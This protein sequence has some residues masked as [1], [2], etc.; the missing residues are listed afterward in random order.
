M[1][2]L[3]HNQTLPKA[4]RKL[5]SRAESFPS[6]L[7]FQ[8]QNKSQNPDPKTQAN[9]KAGFYLQPGQISLSTAV[10]SVH[11]FDHWGRTPAENKN[12]RDWQEFYRF[13]SSKGEETIEKAIT[14][15]PYFYVEAGA[16][17]P[18]RK[19]NFQKNYLE[20]NNEKRFN[21]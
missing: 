4:E 1:G 9:R 18:E 6:C 3:K 12:A 11:R 2:I 13:A 17:V 21:L 10:T 14:Q 8:S 5:S 19:N 7:D 15:S 20:E 16:L